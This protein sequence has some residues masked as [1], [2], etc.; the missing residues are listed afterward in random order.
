MISLDYYET[1]F[2]HNQRKLVML[3][4]IIVTDF[5][6]MEQAFFEADVTRN[7]KVMQLELHK[8]NPIVSNLKYQELS[9]LI[10]K[11]RTFN[12]YDD[13]IALLHSELKFHLNTI[14]VFLK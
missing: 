4:E 6:K 1:L 12:E 9:S 3:R 7:L 13:S 14:Y 5:K 10:E 8:M 11:Y 2:N